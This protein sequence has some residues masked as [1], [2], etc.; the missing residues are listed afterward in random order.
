[1]RNEERLEALMKPKKGCYNYV[2]A[3]SHNL[4]VGLSE[5]AL[6]LREA[7]EEEEADLDTIKDLQER[8][9][10]YMGS[11][12]NR[13]TTD[14]MEVILLSLYG[15]EDWECEKRLYYHA[16][17]SMDLGYPEGYNPCVLRGDMRTRR[18]YYQE[19]DCDD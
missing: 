16:L 2:M 7:S 11:R 1:M 13:I 9:R 15:C 10:R 17:N 18:H 12:L 19:V 4:D 6:N 3:I 14:D 8:I 5:G